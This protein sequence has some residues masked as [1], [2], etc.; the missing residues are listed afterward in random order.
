M[1]LDNIKTWYGMSLQEGQGFCSAAQSA[2]T[3]GE[4]TA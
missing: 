1:E 4:R 2:R 3:P